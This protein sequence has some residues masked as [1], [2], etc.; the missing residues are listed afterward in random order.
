MGLY[1]P[2]GY[3]IGRITFSDSGKDR[4]YNSTNS[5]PSLPLSPWAT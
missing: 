2:A 1:K 4:F 5:N 3:E